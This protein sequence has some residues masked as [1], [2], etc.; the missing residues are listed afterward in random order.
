VP[1]TL[2]KTSPV[3]EFATNPEKAAIC[4]LAARAATEQVRSRVAAGKADGWG[5][6]SIVSVG[7]GA[8]SLEFDPTEMPANTAAVAMS[9]NATPSAPASHALGCRAMRAPIPPDA[10]FVESGSEGFAD[11][12]FDFD[13]E[14]DF[15]D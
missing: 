8:A 3:S 14:F 9:K 1:L 6:G 2:Y 7:T 12:A 11:L 5:R 13:L 15:E 4:E 10:G